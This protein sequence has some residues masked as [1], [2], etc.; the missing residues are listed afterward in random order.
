MKR[1]QDVNV[2]FVEREDDERLGSMLGENKE[3]DPRKR[4]SEG[5]NGW[6]RMLHSRKVREIDR[7]RYSLRC[8][9]LPLFKSHM[10]ARSPP[11]ISPLVQH[12]S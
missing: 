6:R 4:E 9:L 8:N 12:S 2:W 11:D 1:T 10:H 7:Q 5:R 3:V